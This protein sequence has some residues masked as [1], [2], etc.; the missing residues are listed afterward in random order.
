MI[1]KKTFQHVDPSQYGGGD[2]TIGGHFE[3]GGLSQNPSIGTSW[4]KL[5]AFENRSL[6]SVYSIMPGEAFVQEGVVRIDQP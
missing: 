4:W 5:G 3:H 1:A 2:R 6:Q